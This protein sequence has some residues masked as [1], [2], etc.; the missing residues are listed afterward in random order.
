[1]AIQSV[2]R[3]DNLFPDI[4]QCVAGKPSKVIAQRYESIFLAFLASSAAIEAEK[5]DQPVTHVQHQITLAQISLMIL[6][7]KFPRPPP[8]LPKPAWTTN[9]SFRKWSGLNVFA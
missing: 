6:C 1:M 9:T 8:L 2:R 3:V 5:L 7:V 4:V